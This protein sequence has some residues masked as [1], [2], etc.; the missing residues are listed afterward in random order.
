MDKKQGLTICQ[1]QEI[2]FKHKDTI[3]LKVK[4]W[5]N[6][7][8]ANN[9]KHRCSYIS[10]KTDFRTRR[11]IRHK[12]GYYIKWTGN[13]RENC[14][15]QI[16]DNFE[17]PTADITL[18]MLYSLRLG[19][20]PKC[21]LLPLPFN[22]VLEVLVSGRNGNKRHLGWKGRSKIIHVGTWYHFV[23][24]QSLSSVWLFCDSM[25][26]SVPGFPV[27]HHLPELAQTRICWVIDAIQSSYPL[28]SP[29]P[30][31]FN[32]LQHQGL[33]QWV[34]SSHQVAKVLELQ[35]QSFQWKFRTDFL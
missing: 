12:D 19:A 4:G 13:R 9:S 20:K 34:G 3:R 17:N 23:V 28:S 33:F 15:N 27:L 16:K 1:L 7:Y 30:P 24:V 22:I 29:S 14:F 5:R 21:P 18:K 35:H 32:L 25:H 31:D 11:T 10:H 26:C 6:T 2:H 8:S